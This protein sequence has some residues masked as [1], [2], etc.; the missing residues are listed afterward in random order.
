[1]GRAGEQWLVEKIVDVHPSGGE[2]LRVLLAKNPVA[3][4]AASHRYPLVVIAE[5]FGG[6]Q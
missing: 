1:M 4:N 3:E 5:S 6:R 2:E